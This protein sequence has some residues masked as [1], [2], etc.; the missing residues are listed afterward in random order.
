MAPTCIPARFRRYLQISGDGGPKP[1]RRFNNGLISTNLYDVVSDG[2][3]LIA[4]TAGA[5]TWMRPVSDFTG[6][7]HERFQ[8]IGSTVPNPSSGDFTIKGLPEDDFIITLYD[9]TGRE[10]RRIVTWANSIIRS[11]SKIFQRESTSC[12]CASDRRYDHFSFKLICLGKWSGR[13]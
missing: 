4:A 9:L 2:V 6:L 3:N 12:S 1:G 13:E 8:I 7:N 5:S 11:T 10:L